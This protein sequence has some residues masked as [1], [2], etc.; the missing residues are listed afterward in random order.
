MRR[1]LFVKIVEAC[2]ANC[3]YFTHGRNVVGLLDFNPYQ[4]ISAAMRMIAYYIPA[5]Y[6]NEYQNFSKVA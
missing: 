2:K 5:D 1:Q 3:C 4:K 6:T